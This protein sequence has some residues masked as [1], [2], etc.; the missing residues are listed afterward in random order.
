MKISKRIVFFIM[1]CLLFFSGSVVIYAQTDKDSLERIEK[2]LE[3]KEKEKNSANNELE[4]IE[5]EINSINELISENNKTMAATEERIENINKKIEEKKEEIIILEDKILARKD[6]MKQRLVALQHD[7]K[8]SIFIEILIEAESLGDLIDRASAVN[9]LFDA[10][11]DLLKAQEED[12]KQLEIEK[13]EIDKQQKELLEE[14]NKLREQQAELAKNL[15][16]KEE[17]LNEVQKKLE[18]IDSEL[19]GAQQ[20]KAAI[21]A[22]I[23]AAQDLA[24]KERE[25]ASQKAGQSDSNSQNTPGEA[26]KGQ[27]LYVVATAYSP[28]ESGTHTALGYNIQENPNMKLIAVDPTVIPLGSTVW[29]EGYGTA[30]AG[31]TGGAIK[32][33]KIDVLMPTRAEA[34]QWGRRPVKIIILD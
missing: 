23:K 34:L 18:K 31:D 28:E 13:K 27:E 12:M 30:I 26:V 6:I 2:E 8:L 9:T 21:Q 10:D 33:H 25:A 29:V 22:Q 17:S 1:T 3:E 19:S 24:A 15:Q 5:Q 16:K 7:S 20:E 32:G 4:A 11:K 14:Q